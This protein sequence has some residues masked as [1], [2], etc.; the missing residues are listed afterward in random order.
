MRWF[1]RRIPRANVFFDLMGWAS[2]KAWRLK[3]HTLSRRPD[4]IPLMRDEGTIKLGGSNEDYT[5]FGKQS[6]KN[7]FVP[8]N[9]PA[10]HQFEP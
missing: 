8:S 5:H 2:L 7:L 4:Q 3:F 1:G 10:E 6:D 9:W